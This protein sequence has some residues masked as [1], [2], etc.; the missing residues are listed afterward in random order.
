[1]TWYDVATLVIG[2]LCAL[3][4]FVAHRTANKLD[5]LEERTRQL[6]KRDAGQEEL[7]RQIREDVR[8]IKTR[9][10]GGSAE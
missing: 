3:L 4:S 2:I 10:F 8:V 5:G 1:M 9:L 6:E 7:L